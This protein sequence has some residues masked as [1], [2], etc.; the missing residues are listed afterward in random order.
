[1]RNSN[2]IGESALASLRWL[3]EAGADEAIGDVPVNR[4]AAAKPAAVAPAERRTAPA[5]PAAAA[6][7]PPVRPVESVPSPAVSRGASSIEAAR[8]IAERCQTL[9]ELREALDAF[10]GCALKSTATN[11]VFSDGNPDAPLMLVGE[12][13]GREEDLKGLPF[14][15]QSGQLLDRMLSHVGLA[16]ASNVYIAN[17][18]FWRPPGNREPTIEEVAISMPFVERHIALKRPKVLMALGSISA[19]QLLQ[20]TD[21]ITRLRGKWG[22]YSTGGQ[23]IPLIA[24]FHPANL[25]RNPINKRYVWRDLLAVAERLEEIGGAPKAS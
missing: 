1:M 5:A 18:L 25:L 21:G 4:F 22:S 11:L 13:P 8:E 24:T 10:D 3:I 20:R 9:D 16:R 19:K 17:I 6:S 12:A 15:G 23:T 7:R 2:P 14:V